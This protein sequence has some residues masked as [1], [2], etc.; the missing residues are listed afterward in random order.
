MLVQFLSVHKRYETQFEKWKGSNSKFWERSSRKPALKTVMN[1]NPSPFTFLDHILLLQVWVHLFGE[2]ICLSITKIILGW[3]EFH[4][5][6]A[7]H[8][9]PQPGFFLEEG[10]ERTLG[11][12][13]QNLL[14]C[15]EDSKKPNFTA[16]YYINLETE[17]WH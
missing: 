13:L 15:T 17:K 14:F 8:D 11:M 4:C 12:T 9:Q 6:S 3:W 16:S 7:S 5:H 2:R 1:I 10:R